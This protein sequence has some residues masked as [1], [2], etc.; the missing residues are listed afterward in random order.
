METIRQPLYD[1]KVSV[2]FDK[3]FLVNVNPEKFNTQEE[4]EDFL[5]ENDIKYKDW[6]LILY[7]ESKLLTLFENYIK[8][9]REND[10]SFTSYSNR[11]FNLYCWQNS[12]YSINGNKL[13]YDMKW[14]LFLKNN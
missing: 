7:K 2:S 1:H 11:S 4:A 12:L 6:N 10:E 3:S 9:Y 5:Y 13:V 14:N 8:Y